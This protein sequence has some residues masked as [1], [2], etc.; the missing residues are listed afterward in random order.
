MKAKTQKKQQQ[1]DPAWQWDLTPLFEDR[2][3]WEQ[4]L[5][6]SR[7]DVAQVAG[8]RGSFGG[9]PAAAQRALA[10]IYQARERAERVYLYSFLL[11]STDNGNTQRQAMDEQATKM[12][13]D[14]ETAAAFV[15]PE[16]ISLDDAAWQ[17]L[18]D[19]PQ[20][21]AYRQVFTDVARRRPHTLDLEQEKLL[22]MLGDAAQGPER[23]FTMLTDVDMRLPVITD[24]NGDNIELTQA[25]YGLFRRSPDRRVRRRAY[26]AMQ[27]KFLGYKN[28][29]AAVYA[30]SV[31][32]DNYFAG[33]KG[34]QNALHAALFQFDVP[35]SVYESLIQAV[36]RNLPALARYLTLRRKAMKLKQ[37]R[38]YDLYAPIVTQDERDYPF[39]KAKEIVLAALAPLGE[40]YA[41][42]LRR[43]FDEKW[44]DVYEKRGKITGAFSC[45]VYGVHPY[46]LLNYQGRLDDVFTLAHELGHAVH[47][48]LSDEA[49]PFHDHDYSIM[50]AEVASTVNEVLLSR[51][52]VARE[53]DPRRRAAL[54]EHVLEGF[55]TTLFRQT[56]FAEFEWAVHAGEQAGEPV[57]VDTLNQTYA[58]LNAKYYP[59]VENDENAAVEWARIPHFYRAFYVYQYATGYSSAVAI[60]QRILEEGGTE[61]YLNFL[62]LGSSTYPLEQLRRIGVDLT[63]PATVNGALSVFENTCLEFEAALKEMAQ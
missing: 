9:G 10:A 8:L 55:R 43:A 40:K 42:I 23:T 38:H 5:R 39:A 53:Q 31:K 59:N 48:C 3:Q 16:L 14:L 35:V 27:G 50:V 17:Q 52:L 44:I 41:A 4:A 7:K 15:Q 32:F 1:A 46:I 60:A 11:L 2:K 54:L 57:N 33:V 13:V 47:S 26:L 28:T 49:Q 25:N 24:E 36:N 61:D 18:L 21:A 56:L 37:L 58:S 22:A 20:L 12:M 62:S 29:L 6:A 45:G 51:W 19:A 63:S 34:Y 30:N